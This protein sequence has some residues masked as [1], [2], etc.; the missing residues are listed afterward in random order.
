VPTP[1]TA[2]A[3]EKMRRAAKRLAR[4]QQLPYSAALNS[5]AQQQGYAGWQDV[6]RSAPPASAGDLPV[7]PVLPA[8]FDDTPNE[9]RSAAELDMWWLRPFA[10]TR[11]DGRL[12]VRCLDGGALDRPTYYGT[13]DT[14]EGAK[15][16]ASDK[17][18][19]WNA[20][21]D[22]PKALLLDGAW[23]L[24]LEPNRPG[25]PHPVMFAAA[26]QAGA[27][28]FSALLKN[29][30]SAQPEEAAHMISA[31]RDRSAH[32][33]TWDEVDVACRESRHAGVAGIDGREPSLEEIATL[34]T[35]A[36]LRAP[37]EAQAVFTMPE[38]ALHL[39]DFGV[40]DAAAAQ[41]LCERVLQLQQ[42]A[43]SVVV[44]ED[45]GSTHGLKRWEARVRE[46]D[47]LLKRPRQ[48]RLP[49]R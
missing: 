46:V 12:D 25:M 27:S 23:L 49:G 39:F 21:R 31:A 33:P 48:R 7:D 28:E 8:H 2:S 41:A 22:T 16:L 38:L 4:A 44:L 24:V 35:L 3:I 29:L 18:A 40:A 6:R 47:W 43:Q 19:H 15:A 30:K 37:G 10:Q 32:L 26:S 1:L 42:S 45:K 36:R 5:V 20:I 13:A 11:P 14:L 34:L 9:E 17:L